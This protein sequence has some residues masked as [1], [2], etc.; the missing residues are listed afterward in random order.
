MP[1]CWQGQKKK[2]KRKADI[3][4]WQSTR[5]KHFIIPLSHSKY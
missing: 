4:G 5:A 1:G 3:A 2:E